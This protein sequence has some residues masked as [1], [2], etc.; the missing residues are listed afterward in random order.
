[1]SRVTLVSG[2]D[3][4][5]LFPLLAVG[6]ALR[7]RGH[8]VVVVTGEDRRDDVAR[9]GHAFR[10]LPLE[11]PDDRHADLGYRLWELGG[12]LASETAD[13]LAADAPDVVVVDTLTQS[14]AMAAELAGVPWIE[15]VPHHLPDPDEAIPPV[16]LG[17]LPGGGPLRRFD[18][19]RLRSLQSQSLSGGETHR[20]RVRQR[21]GLRGDG[22][23]VLRLVASLPSL[24][25]PRSRWPADT[26]LV[27]PLGWE[28]PWEPLTPP[29]G[30][31]P[32]VVVTDSSASTVPWQLGGY[33]L[34]ALRNTGV[35]IA[36]VSR[37]AW[38]PWP[39]RC[40][41]GWG[42]HGPLLDEA[43][44]AVVPGGAGVLGKA[45][46]RGVPVVAVPV[47]GDQ[48]ESAA[49]V[50]HAGAGLRVRRWQRTRR[51]LRVAV[52]TVLADPAFGRAAR[53]L[54]AEAA[55]LGPSRAAA[56][57]AAVAAGRRPVGLGPRR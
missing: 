35:R 29:M 55:A 57:V 11:W 45:F 41:V 16:G 22:R 7:D 19:A 32:L 49:R 40:V 10:R 18:D 42:P 39:S 6:D 2:P 13:V 56:L 9:G 46:S 30:R 44:V 1:V 3:P 14:G 48:A 8:T 4:G 15:L 5:H 26:H 38:E 36:V 27:G 20:H 28:P 17:R 43:A 54:A 21:L 34:S 23:P 31:E 25:Y 52:H 51:W 53:A 37:G 12:R 50:V 33:A 47:H 24:E